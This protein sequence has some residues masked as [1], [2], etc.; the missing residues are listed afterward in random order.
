[1]KF[2]ANQMSSGMP[3]KYT[4]GVDPIRAKLR[5]TSHPMASKRESQGT[6]QKCSKGDMSGD[7]NLRCKPRIS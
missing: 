4:Q 5:S 2:K 3:L 6:A 7:S 1:M